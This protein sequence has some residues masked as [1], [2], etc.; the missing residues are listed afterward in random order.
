[1]LKVAKVLMF[2]KKCFCFNYSKYLKQKLVVSIVKVCTHALKIISYLL[3]LT[4]KI[5]IKT[6]KF[7][8][9]K[10]NIHL[11]PKL[12]NKYLKN[13]IDKIKARN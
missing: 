12:F 4:Y 2:C 11:K 9:S 10:L 8:S 6:N 1:M 5:K 7:K 3:A 13:W